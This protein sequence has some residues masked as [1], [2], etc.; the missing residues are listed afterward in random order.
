MKNSKSSK[1]SI[2]DHLQALTYKKTPWESLSPDQQSSF[3]VYM[4]NRF[5]SMNPDLIGIIDEFQYL[6][7]GIMTPEAVYKLYLDIL[8]KSKSYFKYTKSKKVSVV[9]S[10]LVGLLSDYFLVSNSEAEEY[11]EILMGQDPEYLIELIRKY[12][13]TE[14][15]IKKILGLK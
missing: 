8:P 1:Y 14:K 6:T 11:G 9:S 15:E 4:I 13:K 12:G 5:L 7:I 10:E 3:S 2:F